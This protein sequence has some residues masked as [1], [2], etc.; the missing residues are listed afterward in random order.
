MISIAYEYDY[1]TGLVATLPCMWTYLDIAERHRERLARNK[2]E[3]YKKWASVYYSE[4]YRELLQTLLKV[5]DSSNKRVEDLE[6][7]FL[8]SLKYEYLFWDASY[9]LEKWLV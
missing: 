8:R 2:V 6:I 9:K 4:I 7:V 5:I 1:W 3:I